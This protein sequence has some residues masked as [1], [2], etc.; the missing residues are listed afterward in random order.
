MTR[1]MGTMV[2]VVGDDNEKHRCLV[3]LMKEVHLCLGIPFQ[4][5]LPPA[6]ILLPL[7]DIQPLDVSRDM[8][9]EQQY[10]C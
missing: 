1:S 6:H 2:Q 5:P 4:N 10:L 7:V 3:E 9:V 8:P